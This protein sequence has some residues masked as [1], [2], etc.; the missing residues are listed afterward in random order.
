MKATDYL[1]ASFFLAASMAN[2]NA[3]RART[4]KEEKALRAKA[5]RLEKRGTRFLHA[6][7]AA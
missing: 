7:P 5:S 4:R 1:A 6:K 2:H 3:S